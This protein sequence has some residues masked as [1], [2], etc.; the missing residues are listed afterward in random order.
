MYYVSSKRTYVIA[1][2]G[3]DDIHIQYYNSFHLNI[4]TVDLVIFARFKFSQIS[5]GGQIREFKNLA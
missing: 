2:N 1:M 4:H 3:P 5:R